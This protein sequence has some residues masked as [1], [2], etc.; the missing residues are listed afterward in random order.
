MDSTVVKLFKEISETVAGFGELLFRGK[1]TKTNYIYRG[2]EGVEMFYRKRSWIA[3]F[4]CAKLVEYAPIHLDDISSKDSPKM[5]HFLGGGGF[6][7]Y[8]SFRSILGYI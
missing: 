8:S 7:I 2:H 3:K 6:D 4:R 5:L 1:G